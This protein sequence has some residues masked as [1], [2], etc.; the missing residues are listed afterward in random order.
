MVKIPPQY[1]KQLDLTTGTRLEIHIKEKNLIVKK[2]SL[3]TFLKQI[4][5][6]NLHCSLW[7][8]K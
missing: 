4:N 8:A 5:K 1:I 7:E 3:N 2:N 6:K